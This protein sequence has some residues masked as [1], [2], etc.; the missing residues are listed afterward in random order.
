MYISLYIITDD[1]Q[2]FKQDVDKYSARKEL[3]PVQVE[4]LCESMEAPK[5]LAQRISI[6]GAKKE[7]N[8]LTVTSPIKCLTG[9]WKLTLL[10]V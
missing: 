6:K 4:V 1:L 7:C 9:E 10:N 2:I 5:H 8:F 3:C